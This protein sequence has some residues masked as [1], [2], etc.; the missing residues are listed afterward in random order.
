M[1][2]GKLEGL[3]ASLDATR[4][5]A[6]GLSRAEMSR[7]LSEWIVD[8]GGWARCGSLTPLFLMDSCHGGL[9]AAKAGSAFTVP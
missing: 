1:I 6:L 7:W 8:T 4:R 9:L 3:S 5:S 2:V